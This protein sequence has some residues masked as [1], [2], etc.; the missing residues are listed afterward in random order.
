VTGGAVVI[1]IGNAWCGDDAAGLLVAER[2]RE[3]LPQVPVV[4]IEGEPSRLL[5]AMSGFDPVVIVDAVR[6][7]EAEAGAIRRIDA[8]TSSLPE[9][10]GASTH[11]FSLGDAIELARSLGRLPERLV[12][13][14]IDGC[15]FELGTEPD[16]AIAQAAD[17]VVQR[18]ATELEEA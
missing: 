16:P 8:T 1:G 17:E 6:S 2:V 7:G 9:T 15:S 5:D 10:F 14:G 3:R 4:E 18:I 12:V 13:Y 11:H